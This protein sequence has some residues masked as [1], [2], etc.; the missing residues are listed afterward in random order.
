MEILIPKE[1][2]SKIEKTGK[3]VDKFCE[4]AIIEYIKKFH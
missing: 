4:E 2:Y 1:L 3:D